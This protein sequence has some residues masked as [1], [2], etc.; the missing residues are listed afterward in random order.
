MKGDT[1]ALKKAQDVIGVLRT[2]AEQ[3]QQSV[4][5]ALQAPG[6]TVAY[7]GDSKDKASVPEQPLRVVAPDSQQVDAESE[8]QSF[9]CRPPCNKSF[10]SQKALTW[11]QNKPTCK[12]NWDSEMFQL[13]A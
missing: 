10:Q 8:A 6:K 2:G 13:K 7:S 3:R 4:D 11:H 12:A 5:G 1:A 9:T